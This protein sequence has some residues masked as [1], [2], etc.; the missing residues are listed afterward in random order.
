MSETPNERS[1]NQVTLREHLETALTGFQREL[2]RRLL[3]TER[4]FT[5]RFDGQAVAVALATAA[6]E[7]EIVVAMTASQQAA[8]KIE[9]ANDKR[10]LTINDFIAS[11]GL[12]VAKQMPRDEAQV[13]LNSLSEKVETITRRIALSE[14]SDKGMKAGWLILVG[15]IS[16]AAAAT[17]IFVATT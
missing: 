8:G 6:R 1:T 16:L 17:S 15:L 5:E 14:G 12:L 7:R 4:R 9:A 3:D 13:Q 11:L 10:D 2:D